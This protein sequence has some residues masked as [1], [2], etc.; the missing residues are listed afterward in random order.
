MVWKPK[1]KELTLEE[2]IKFA[3]KELAPFWFGSAPLLAGIKT[4]Q[5][6]T[7][8]P[9]DPN[10]NHHIWALFFIDP[11]DFAG[12][13][14]IQ[15][16]REIHRRYSEMN[17]KVL[18]ILK[19]HYP[20]IREK[21]PIEQLIRQH[22]IPYPVVAD[23]DQML[24][25]AFGVHTYPKLILLHQGKSVFE[26]ASARWL[27]HTEGEIQK[28]LRNQDPGL[29]LLPLFEPTYA[30]FQDV[31]R[32]ELGRGKGTTFPLPR[33]SPPQQ[34]FGAALFTAQKPETLDFLSTES[35]EKNLYIFGNWIQ[36]GDRIITS[37]PHAKMAF[38][39]PTSNISIVAQSVAKAKTL[40]KLTVEINE[41]PVFDTFAGSDLSTDDEGQS[42]IRLEDPRIYHLAMKLPKK[43]REISLKFPLANRIPIAIYGLR[44]SETS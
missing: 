19:P 30:W 4:A 15:F 18:L 39:S 14:T 1:E 44:F 24:C 25:T 26:R 41:N 32:I 3:K 29:A 10:F 11:T 8:Y 7:S 6:A 37:D 2:A 43:M 40:A 13:M 9:L 23:S 35:T 5:G 38:L 20:F 36:D 22:Q 33:F 12:M 42:V 28:F 21:F 31:L 16:A 17:V 34:G 27:N